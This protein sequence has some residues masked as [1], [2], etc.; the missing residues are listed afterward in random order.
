VPELRISEII[1]NSRVLWPKFSYLQLVPT[2]FY[3]LP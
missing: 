3:H 2:T 1:S